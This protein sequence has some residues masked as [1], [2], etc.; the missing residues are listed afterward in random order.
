[1]CRAD[2]DLADEGE[3]DEN[4]RVGVSGPEERLLKGRGGNLPP[5]HPQHEPAAGLDRASRR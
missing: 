1:M 2:Q 5:Q 3:D 4:P